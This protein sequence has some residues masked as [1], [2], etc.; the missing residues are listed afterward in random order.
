MIDW[1]PWARR[2]PGP[3][4]HCGYKTPIG[5]YWINPRCDRKYG[6]L[7]HSSGGRFQPGNMPVDIMA[8]AGNSWPLSVFR[9]GIV[10]QHYPLRTVCWHAGSPMANLLLEGIE[11]D[12]YHDELWTPEQT[13]S[14]KR[15]LQE[16]W[17]YGPPKWGGSIRLGLITRHFPDEEQASIK[18]RIMIDGWNLWDHNM[19][20]PTDCPDGRNDPH[21]QEIISWLEEGDTATDWP[22]EKAKLSRDFERWLSLY[23]LTQKEKDDTTRQFVEDARAR[24][25]YQR[26]ISWRLPAIGS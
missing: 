24:E 22:L 18:T 10:E 21:R 5:G 20:S 11:M 15:V 19:L 4:E 25:F 13:A 23:P 16:T 14:L 2:A 8:A 7:I 3:E 17:D 12:G 6:D 26:Q 9:D 1:L